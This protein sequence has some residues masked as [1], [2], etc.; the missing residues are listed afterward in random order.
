MK[1]ESN[2]QGNDHLSCIVS[3]M[4]ICPSKLSSKFAQTQIALL[5]FRNP[6]PRCLDYEM[7]NW[8]PSP[9]LF[10]CFGITNCKY[11][12][13]CLW[14]ITLAICNSYK[15]HVQYRLTKLSLSFRLGF[16]EP[17]HNNAYALYIYILSLHFR[18]LKWH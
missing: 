6:I 1:I 10:F 8:G 4:W 9:I 17:R 3:N 16:S 7:R 13:S 5:I 2:F 18:F 15:T 12:I 11:D 14:Y